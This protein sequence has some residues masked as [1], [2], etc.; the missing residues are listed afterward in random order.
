M[1]DEQTEQ[2]MLMQNRNLVLDDLAK[3]LWMFKHKIG[4]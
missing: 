2:F 1:K 4:L 3:M